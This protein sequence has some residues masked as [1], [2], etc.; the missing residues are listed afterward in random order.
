ML[1][2]NTH[3]AIGVH[4]MTALGVRA[5]EPLPSEL[6]AGSVNTNPAFLRAVIG[7]LRDAG[8]VAT[9][10]GKGGGATLARPAGEITLLDVYRATVRD[11]G[12]NTHDCG[13]NNPCPVA[14]TIVGYLDALSSDLDAALAAK[15]AERTIADVAKLVMHEH[16]AHAV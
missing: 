16:A 13:T 3:F 1:T 15:L 9:K 6:L 2:Q 8:L 4:V 12:L 5:P 7:E 14:G 11:P 10:L